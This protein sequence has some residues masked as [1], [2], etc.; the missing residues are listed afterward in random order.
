MVYKNNNNK[1]LSCSGPYTNLYKNNR[2]LTLSVQRIV[3]P[4]AL[5]YSGPND[6]DDDDDNNNN[7]LCVEDVKIASIRSN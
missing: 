4:L 2:F 7:N 1:A 6:D 3:G 5:K